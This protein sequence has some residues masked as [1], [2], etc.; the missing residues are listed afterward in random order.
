M[1]DA[2]AACDLAGGGLEA[3]G[4]SDGALPLRP[5]PLCGACWQGPARSKRD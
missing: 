4:E 2:C 3:R 1:I 5:T